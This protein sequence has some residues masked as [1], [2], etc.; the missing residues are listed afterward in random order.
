MSEISKDAIFHTVLIAQR[1]FCLSA[2]SY[3]LAPLQLIENHVSPF[4]VLNYC[5]WAT[6]ATLLMDDADLMPDFV[7]ASWISFAMTMTFAGL[8]Y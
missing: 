4:V 7:I 6:T 1:K 2:L 5:S 8:L 3:S